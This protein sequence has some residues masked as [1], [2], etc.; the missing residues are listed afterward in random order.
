MAETVQL[1]SFIIGS[2]HARYERVSVCSALGL[3][4]LSD[5]HDDCG[6]S[7]QMDGG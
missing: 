2:R 1:L 5:L 3:I 4:K 6:E 7:E